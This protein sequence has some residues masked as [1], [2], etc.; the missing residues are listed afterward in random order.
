VYGTETSSDSTGSGAIA[1]P[2]GL[3]FGFRLS[4]GAQLQVQAFPMP[5]GSLWGTLL[6]VVPQACGPSEALGGTVV[7]TRR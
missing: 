5:D 4:Q 6:F 7:V 3:I 2:P 1:S